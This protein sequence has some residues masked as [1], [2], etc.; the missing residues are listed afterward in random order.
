[1]GDRL[2]HAADHDHDRNAMDHVR[3][4]ACPQ[5]SERGAA[6]LTSFTVAVPI[7]LLLLFVVVFRGA[8]GAGVAPGVT[9]GHAEPR[10]V[11]R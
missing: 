3:L 4:P 7:T 11:A 9:R 6:S 1:M 10:R 8:F 2:A 5:C